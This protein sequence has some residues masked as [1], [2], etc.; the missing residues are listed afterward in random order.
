MIP[1]WDSKEFQHPDAARSKVPPWIKHWTRSLSDQ[2]Y[3]D[4]TL[5]ERGLL[6]DLRSEYA[7][8]LRALPLDTK[9]LTRRLSCKVSRRSLERLRD[10]G[11][12]QFSASKP[13]SPPAGIDARPDGNGDGYIFPR[14]N[15]PASRKRTPFSAIPGQLCPE[16]ELAPPHHTVDCTHAP[17][18]QPTP[19]EPVDP[20]PF[21]DTEP[22]ID[23]EL[24]TYHELTA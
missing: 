24:D 5:A 8:T 9:S 6:A 19:L 4:L 12:I 15:K 20:S 23:T 17:G 16:C 11:F 18:R 13:A 10:A 1:N 21:D 14:K 3:L 22:D 2:A 7:R